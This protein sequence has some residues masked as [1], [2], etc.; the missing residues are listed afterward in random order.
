MKQARKVLGDARVLELIENH[1]RDAAAGI[2]LRKPFVMESQTCGVCGVP[3]VRQASGRLRCNACRNARYRAAHPRAEPLLSAEDEAVAFVV[4]LARAGTQA[5][6]AKAMGK[7]Q[8]VVS[9]RLKKARAL[10]GDECVKALLLSNLS[11]DRYRTSLLYPFTRN[12]LVCSKCGG[13]RTPLPSTG[14]LVCRA[15]ASARNAEYKAR[16]DVRVKAAAAEYR[17]RNRDALIEKSRA[18]R[19]AHPEKNAAYYAANAE[20]VKANVQAYREANKDKIAEYHRHRA[21]MDP[22]FVEARNARHRAW[23]KRNPHKVNAD[24]ARRQLRLKRAYVSWA[25]D[26]LIE[27]FYSLARL[28]TEVTGIPWEVDHIVPLNSDLV[29]GLHWEGN[30]QVIPAARNLEKGNRWWPAMPDERPGCCAFHEAPFFY[31]EAEDAR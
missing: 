30:L 13:A 19:E 28:R 11:D 15:C 6:A 7:S 12:Q 16:H 23:K 4:L 24:T 29:C 26:E 18:Y 14:E 8:A 17:A 22:A 21:A 9:D 25:S 1:K 3:K 10:L 5:A 2:T 27:E 31:L 20:R